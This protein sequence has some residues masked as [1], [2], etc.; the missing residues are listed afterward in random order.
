[1]FITQL[2][3]HTTRPHPFYYNVN[4]PAISKKDYLKR[5]VEYNKAMA[6]YNPKSESMIQYNYSDIVDLKIYEKIY[7]NKTLID[8]INSNETD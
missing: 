6:H 1:M 8:S 4:L 5:I 7:E 3:K 2:L